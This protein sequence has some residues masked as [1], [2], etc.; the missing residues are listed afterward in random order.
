ME[1]LYFI[2][3][4][5]SSTCYRSM[6]YVFLCSITCKVSSIALLPNNPHFK[7]TSNDHRSDEWNNVNGMELFFLSFERERT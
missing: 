5:Y 4:H 7:I 1:S 2:D 3:F 6:F